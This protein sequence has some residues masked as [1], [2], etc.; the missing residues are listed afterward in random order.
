MTPKLQ[1]KI[2]ITAADVP[3][4]PGRSCLAGTRQHRRFRQASSPALRATAPSDRPFAGDLLQ[5]QELPSIHQAERSN[6]THFP[7]HANTRNHKSPNISQAHREPLPQQ[8]S[9][10]PPQDK[11][12]RAPIDCASDRPA[13]DFHT[14]ST[15]P[16]RTP[17]NL[18]SPAQTS[19]ISR[20][21][22]ASPIPPHRLDRHRD[23]RPTKPYAK[24]YKANQH[25]PA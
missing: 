15:T 3:S 16:A 1:N 24:I 17:R 13:Q 9:S 5:S 8:P 4:P 25:Q 18:L 2:L 21:L 11:A 22:P 23:W 19:T 14:H 6:H 20:Q 10:R 7:E 12:M